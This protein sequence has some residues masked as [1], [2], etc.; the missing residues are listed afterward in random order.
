MDFLILRATDHAGY[1]ETRLILM[2]V[3]LA[4][5]GYFIY[6]KRDRR[7]LLMF[8]SGIISATLME[9]VLQI[10]G[11]RGPG[12]R[13]SVFGFTMPKIAGPILQGISEG[14]AWS[15]IAFW[16]ADLRSTHTR[17][18][19]WLVFSAVCII[20]VVLAFVVGVMARNR[21]VSSIRSMS[22]SMPI[23]IVTGIIFISLFIAWRKDALS[24]LANYYGGLLLFAFLNYEPL[25][26]MGARYI[27]E[28]SG[29][30]IVPATMPYQIIAMFLS[31]VFE[32]AGGKLHYFMIPFA[33]GLVSLRG[34]QD[35]RPRE[36]YSTQHLQ[37]LAQ[38]GW[39]KKSKPF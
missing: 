17:Q 3:S 12:F 1:Y 35:T 37:D 24:D 20:V 23:F 5:A 25:H 15:V 28:F 8:M 29:S 26:L 16:F 11:L 7:Y 31:H 4:I 34:R 9:Y 39:R 10:S 27:G 18:K 13:L 33:L 6:Y 36:R 14:G 32:S 2:A 38:R 19:Q 30:Q 21:P 22:A